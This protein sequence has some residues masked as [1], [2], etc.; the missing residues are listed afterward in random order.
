M[1]RDHSEADGAVA[2]L[3]RQL[4]RYAPDR[5]PMQHAT[6][7][8]HLGVALLGQGQVEEATAA[9][10]IAARLFEPAPVEH[11]KA[12]NMLGAA[13]RGRGALDDAAEAFAAAAAAFDE[14]GLAQEHGAALYN[15][16]LVHADA[17]RHDDAIACYRDAWRRFEGAGLV[18]QAAAASRELGAAQLRGGE[19]EAAAD[20]LAQ[21]V[22]L[23]E[24]AGDEPGR[25]AAANAL[26]LAHLALDRPQEATDAFQAA[27]AANPR[28]LRAQG[29][30]MA[31]ANLALAHERGGDAP[32]ARLAARQALGVPSA[33]QPVAAQAAG[34]LQRLGTGEDDLVRVVEQESPEGRAAVL[35]AEVARWVDADP[36]ERGAAVDRWIDGQL[37]RPGRAP[38]LA[39]ALLGALLELP[40]ADMETIVGDVVRGAGARDPEEQKRFRDAVSRAMIRFH[41]PQWARMK[42]T[43]NRTARQLGEDAGWD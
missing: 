29:Y 27:V 9:L 19:P 33:P 2:E 16:G 24:R 1:S 11:A 10:R 43:F 15:L 4:E 25:G 21:A 41:G 42:D 13:L 8:F 31:T 12:V 23:F 6:A 14:Q 34:V 38:E 39:Q 3:R 18:A 7:Q 26:G 5:Y 32:R 28:R 37:A 40:P 22:E 20:V 30:A 36:G 17:H 35:R